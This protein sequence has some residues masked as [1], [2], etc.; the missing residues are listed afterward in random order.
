MPRDKESP[1]QLADVEKRAASSKTFVIP[2]REER[3]DLWP[4]DQAKVVF[5][6]IGE[7]LWVRVMD[8]LDG[9]VY[10][11][12]IVSSPLYSDC[13]MGER[14]VFGPEHVADISRKSIPGFDRPLERRRLGTKTLLQ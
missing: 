14:L 13:R 5:E 3:E 11:G 7:R 6:G 10:L 2:S 8:V 12:S 9:C 1:W 4:G